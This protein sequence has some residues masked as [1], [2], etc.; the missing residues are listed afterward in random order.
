MLVFYGTKTVPIGTDEITMRCPSC[1]AHA[2]ADLMVSS[3]YFHI[4]FLPMSP[5]SKEAYVVCHKC[6]LKRAG[7]PFDRDLFSSYYE[8]KS[9]FRHPFYTYAGVAIIGGIILLGMVIRVIN[10]QAV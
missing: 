3:K 4:Y 9:K 2:S 8:I 6:G 7:L 10:G 1:E 5:Y